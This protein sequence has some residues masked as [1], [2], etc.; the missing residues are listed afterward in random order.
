MA[1]TLPTQFAAATTAS[2]QQKFA[3]ALVVTA[4]TVKAETP[5]GSVAR[6]RKRQAFA[7]AVLANPGSANA[8]GWVPSPQTIAATY[9]L[10]SAGL[11]DTTADATIQSTLTANFEVIA[12]FSQADN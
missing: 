2:F 9:A 4:R 10:A 8:T 7:D 6:N 1:A 12:G 3:I 5:S 11:D